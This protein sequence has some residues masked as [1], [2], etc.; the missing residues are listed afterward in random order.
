MK[1]YPP[2]VWRAPGGPGQPGATPGGAEYSRANSSGPGWSRTIAGY[3]PRGATRGHSGGFARDFLGSPGVAWNHP[4]RSGIT[5]DGDG[6]RC[7]PGPPGITRALGQPEITPG[8]P[9][10]LYGSKRTASFLAG[11]CEVVIWHTDR[12]QSGPI[13]LLSGLRIAGELN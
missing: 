13:S 7:H 2:R 12:L 1:T 8:N 10:P 3:P 4:K 6:S 5:R 9:V 11:P